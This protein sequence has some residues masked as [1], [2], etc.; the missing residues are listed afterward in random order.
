MAGNAISWTAYGRLRIEDRGVS[1][2]H[3]SAFIS[4]LDP[5]SS[6]L[7]TPLDEVIFLCHLLTLFFHL[8]IAAS[9][10]AGFDLN[11]DFLEQR[12]W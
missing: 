2:T 6:I 12:C 3:C 1:K 7:I 4:I 9:A 10:V 11:P 8:V 5:Q